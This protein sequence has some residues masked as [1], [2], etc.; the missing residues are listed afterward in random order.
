MADKLIIDILWLVFC[1]VL[2][3]MMQAGFGCLESGLTRAKNSI[4]VAIKNLTDFAVASAIFWIF[5][6]GLMFGPTEGGW[7]GTS[8]FLLPLDKDPRQVVFFLFEVMFCSTAVTIIS[9]AVAERIR[10]S[11]YIIVAVVVSAITYPVFGHWAWN[12]IDTGVFTGWLGSLGFRDFAGSTAVHSV[13]GWVALAVLVIIGSREGR[14]PPNQKPQKIRGHNIPL[15]VLGVFLL[16][17]GWMGFNGGSNLALDNRVI[18]ILVNT[19]LAGVS[20]LLVTLMVGWYLKRHAYVDLVINGSLAGLVAI[21]A[22]SHA[23]SAGSAVLIGGI[24]GLV[25][26]GVDT[27][28]ERFRVDDAVGAIPVHLG[29]GVW[30]TLAVALFSDYKI[31]K[32]Q[33]TFLQQ[34]EVQTLGIIVCFFWAFAL[35]YVLF[36]IMNRYF[37]LRVT[38]E[39]EYLGLNISEHGA[40]TELNDLFREMDHQAKSGDLSLRVEMEPFTEVGQIA[41]RYNQVMDSL[42]DIVSHNDLILNSAGEGIYGIDLKG[43]ATFVNTAMIHMIG[44]TKEELLGKTLHPVL[45]HSKADGKFYSM[46]ECPMHAVLKDGTTHH[47]DDEVFW[48]KDGSYFPVEYLCTPII[49]NGRL[50]GAVVIFQDLTKRKEGEKRLRESQEHYA[51]LVDSIHGIVWE[52]NAETFQFTF[53]SRFAERLLGY[54]VRQWCDEPSFWKDHIHPDD[55]EW[56]VQFCVSATADKKAHI[57]EY[58]MIARDGRTVWLKD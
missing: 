5:G 39:N 52:A 26:L 12:G 34:L 57:F 20:G 54:P 3:F 42:E 6:F 13:A 56:V 9:G 47:K 31:L 7:I 49:K 38:P 37:P 33:L 30:G 58:R 55:R 53:V 2:V 29:A 27:L 48:K 16:W 8:N 22:S 35:P 10:F 51:S 28:L 23:V 44:W 1:S 46:D 32:S 43:H 40:S 18:I 17:I 4:N 15:S 11:S 36:R 50:I 21:T 24:G 41:H 25:M 19:L 45:H 14:F